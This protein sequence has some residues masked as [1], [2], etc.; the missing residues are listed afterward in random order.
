MAL[1]Q[2]LQGENSQVQTG[3]PAAVGRVYRQERQKIGTTPIRYAGKCT[4]IH[5][6]DRP[7]LFDE[8]QKV[9]RRFRPDRH[10]QGRNERGQP[11]SPVKTRCLPV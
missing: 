5:G 4:K 2:D 6:E 11:A 1:G 3:P 10:D 9:N 8:Q 7:L